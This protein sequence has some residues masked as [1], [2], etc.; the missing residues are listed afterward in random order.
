VWCCSPGSRFRCCCHGPSCPIGHKCCCRWRKFRY[1]RGT[2]R[3]CGPV[4]GCASH[5]GLPSPRCGDSRCPS[6]SRPGA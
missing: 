1:G 2:G 4:P 3:G 6:G 5:R